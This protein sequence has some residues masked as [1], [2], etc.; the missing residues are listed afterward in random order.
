MELR[1]VVHHDELYPLT[2]YPGF[3]SFVLSLWTNYD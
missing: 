1:E 2:G 3:I